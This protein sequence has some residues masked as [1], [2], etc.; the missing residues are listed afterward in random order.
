LGVKEVIITLGSQGSIVYKG[1]A[2]NEIPAFM[3]KQVVDATGCGDTYMAGYLWKKIA[4][5][6]VQESGEFGAAMA[7]WKIQSSGP[8]M[9][10]VE[11]VENII[12][13]KGGET[14]ERILP[15]LSSTY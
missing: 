12:E 6:T 4:G 10:S 8:F 9:G 5:G 11:Q 14:Y 2:F 1:G 13:G 3:P 15:I 7:T